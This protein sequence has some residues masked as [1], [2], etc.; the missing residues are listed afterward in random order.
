MNDNY[1]AAFIIV[2][3]SHVGAMGQLC[4][5]RPRRTAHK[6]IIDVHDCGRQPGSHC[7]FVSRIECAPN[8]PTH[9]K[10]A[11]LKG[12]HIRKSLFFMMM[13]ASPAHIFCL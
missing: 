6:R 9:G 5:I 10:C 2:T 12:R 8:V 3:R 13:A 4:V 7:L 11:A 1:E